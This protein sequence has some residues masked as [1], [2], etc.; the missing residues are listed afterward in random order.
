MKSITTKEL[1]D[2]LDKENLNYEQIY[3]QIVFLEGRVNFYL[4]RGNETIDEYSRE[5]LGLVHEYQK[6]RSK[7][8]Y[9]KPLI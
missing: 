5:V 4:G 9:I 7:I 3:E 6:Y 2:L 1:F 8:R